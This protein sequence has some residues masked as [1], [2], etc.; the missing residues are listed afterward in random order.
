[1][2]WEHYFQQKIMRQF[3]QRSLILSLLFG[4]LILSWGAIASNATAAVYQM[5]EAPGQMLYQ[6]R[7]T[8][9]DEI[10]EPWQVVLFK[11]EK[12]NGENSIHL[13]LVG[14]PDLTNFAHPQP[15][16][17]FTSTGKVLLAEDFFATESPA[18][19]VGEFDFQTVLPQLP[20][21]ASVQLLLKMKDESA[22]A[23]RIPAEVVLEWH[24]IVQ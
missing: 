17:V 4:L 8:L 7:H 3:F 21:V 22:I 11:R 10:D 23:L 1:M 19:N 24:L 6:S 13:R 2:V 18:D 12:D 20:Q 5:E 16:K 14:F 15:L 9:R